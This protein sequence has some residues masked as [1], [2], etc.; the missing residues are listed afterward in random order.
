M[1]Q[2]QQL[3]LE[4]DRNNSWSI[5]QL[6]LAKDLVSKDIGLQTISILGQVTR[7][8]ESSVNPSDGNCPNSRV[9][10]NDKQVSC[11]KELS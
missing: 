8:A 4:V 3:E 2:M 10:N 6:S 9:R 7:W 1:F 5:Q 11:V